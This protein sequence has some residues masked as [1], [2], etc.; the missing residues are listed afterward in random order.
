MTAVWV[1]LAGGLGT[2]AR[3]FVG[4][5]SERWLPGRFPWGTLIVNLLGSFIIGFVIA[6][7]AA[8]GALEARTRVAITTGFLG[9]FT[10]YSAFAYDS[11]MMLERHHAKLFALY[12]GAT[13]LVAMAGCYAGILLGRQAFATD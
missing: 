5:G 12:V 10:T 8:R 6:A 13:L 1:G 11:V 3:Y 9:G 2:L 4:L 7:F